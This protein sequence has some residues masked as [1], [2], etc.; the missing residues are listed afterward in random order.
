MNGDGANHAMSSG[1]SRGGLLTQTNHIATE[2]YNEG[3]FDLRSWQHGQGILKKSSGRDESSCPQIT[4]SIEHSLCSQMELKC[5]L[6]ALLPFIFVSV[7]L[8]LRWCLLRKS[9]ISK[10]YLG[11]GYFLLRSS[12]ER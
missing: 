6:H 3:V 8:Q 2:H 7:G 11:P 9:K 10:T 1:N 12:R 4:C 5:L